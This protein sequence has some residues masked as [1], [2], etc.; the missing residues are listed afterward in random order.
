MSEKPGPVIARRNDEAI[1][2]QATTDYN[3]LCSM[4]PDCFTAFAG[5]GCPV[6]ICDGDFRDSHASGKCI[7]YFQTNPDHEKE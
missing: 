6:V 7:L 2:V 4:R 1:P 5:D 3:R